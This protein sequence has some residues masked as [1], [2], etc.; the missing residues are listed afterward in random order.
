MYKAEASK[1]FEKDLKKIPKEVVKEI[2]DRWIP[3]L[4]EN[5]HRGERMHG[6]SLRAFWKLPFRFKR[7]DYRLVY[8]IYEREIVIVLLAIGSRENFY[9][10]IERRFG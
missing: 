5:P 7:N 9:K 3:Y 4:Q 2:V 10:R 1:S 6:K 8:Q